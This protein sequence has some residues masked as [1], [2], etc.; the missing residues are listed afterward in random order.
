MTETPGPAQ[1]PAHSTKPSYFTVD[2]NQTPY[3]VAWEITRACALAC[4]HCRAEAIPRRDPRELSTEEGFRLIDQVVEI[5]R[6]ILVITGGDP[7]MRRDVY[8]LLAYASGRGLRVALSPSA[9]RLVTR[10]ALER[11]KASGTQM[12]HLSLDGASA[13]VHDRFRG[14]AGSYQRTLEILRDAQDVGLPLQIGTTVS[15]YNAG[16]LP[17]IAEQVAAI[18]ARVWSVFFLVPTGR[19]KAA[20]MLSAHE[21]ERV[22][23]WLYQLSAQ[24]PFH[25]RTVA[26]PHYRRVV[27]QQRGTVSSG[28]NS[29]DHPRWELTGAGY[30]FREGQADA[31]RGVNDGNGFCFISHIGD[32]CPSGFL[33]LPAGNVREQP[34]ATIYRAA[35][36]F[37]ALRD[38]TALKGKCGVCE[39]KRICGGSRARAYALTG[40]YLAADPSCVYQPATCARL[41]W[42]AGAASSTGG[43]KP[44]GA[45]PKDTSL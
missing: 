21:H 22:L 29:T 8:D 9:T 40:D 33:Q 38:E 24:V 2:F 43:P 23:E 25:V 41:P 3:T 13:Q 15:R 26:A 19:G 28:S 18:G 45:V 44:A 5:G 30:A 34:L 39:F 42:N 36:L 6:P 31:A 12:L 10:R 17:A 16:D 37:R 20:D 35:P 11:V 14:V 7:M 32:V 4:V 27:L 1:R